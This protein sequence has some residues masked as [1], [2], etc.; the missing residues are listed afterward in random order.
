MSLTAP[1]GIILLHK[2]ERTTVATSL[3]GC[4]E[5]MSESLIERP[6]TFPSLVFTLTTPYCVSR[7]LNPM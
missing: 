5:Q 7:C 3:T 6:A 2:S 1:S 4:M